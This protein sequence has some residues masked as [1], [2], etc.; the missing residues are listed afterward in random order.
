MLT[1]FMCLKTANM[2]EPVIVTD[3]MLPGKPLPKYI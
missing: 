1:L 3:D 2:Y